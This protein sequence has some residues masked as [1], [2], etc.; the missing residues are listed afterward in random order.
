MATGSR[1]PNRPRWNGLVRLPPSLSLVGWALYGMGW[2][3]WLTSLNLPWLP[4]F[5]PGLA[6]PTGAMLLFEAVLAFFPGR[7]G[8][9]WWARP[10]VV[11]YYLGL[12]AA[13]VWLS[14][15]SRTMPFG[16]VVR[17]F[18]LG[19]LPMPWI[20][21]EPWCGIPHH[22]RPGAA[23]LMVGS[24]LICLGVWLIPPQAARPPDSPRPGTTLF[25]SP[26]LG[27]PGKAAQGRQPQGP[28]EKLWPRIL[29]WMER[30]L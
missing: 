21:T 1:E 30:H 28:A 7:D 4:P 20:M 27:W 18:T 14:K 3:C 22:P 29:R 5:A 12:I 2:G 26:P 9:I 6:F 8:L 25:P 11:I 24:S 13:L 19:L 23:F 10:V 17:I 16:R 15:A